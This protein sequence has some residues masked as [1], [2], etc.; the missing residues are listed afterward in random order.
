MPRE[1]VILNLSKEALISSQ[2]LSVLVRPKQKLIFESILPMKVKA[3][4]LMYR[5]IKK[6]LLSA[7][8]FFCFIQIASAASIDVYVHNVNG[9]VVS[10]A[11]VILYPVYQTMYTD[12][13]GYVR[14]YGLDYGNFTYEVYYD[15]T[16][17]EEF[18]GGEE[19]ISLQEPLITRDFTRNWPYKYDDTLPADPYVGETIAITVTV[20]N[21]L[22]FSRNVKVE[23]WVDRS[24]TSGWDYQSLSNAQSISGGGST[25][26]FT[27]NNITPSDSG[28]YYYKA[29]VLSWNDGANNGAGGYIV[30]DTMNWEIAFTA[31]YQTSTVDIYVENVNGSKIE[32]AEV[33]LGGNTVTTDINGRARF[34]SVI[35]D[36]YPYEV[37]YDGTGTREFWGDDSIE[38][39]GPSESE[40]FRRNW[41]YK[42]DGTLPPDPYVGETVTITVTVRNNL[43]IPRNVKV[44]LWVDRNKTTDGEY[45][46]VSNAQSISGGGSTK[47]FT[48]NN[49]TPSDS[50]TYYYKAHVLS[51]NDG[52]NN[53]AGGYI[54]TDT[55]NWD[56]AF[57]VETV[58]SPEQELFDDFSYD[59]PYDTN[60][61][62]A[63]WYIRHGSGGGPGSSDASWSRD[64]VQFVADPSDPNNTLL[65][66]IS[67]THGTS[68]T[69]VQA[70][71]GYNKKIF[72]DGTFAARVNFAQ[73]PILWDDLTVQAFFSINT[74]AP[75]AE[76]DF[77]YLAYDNSQWWGPGLYETSWDNYIDGLP[78]SEQPR[79][80]DYQSNNIEGWH[81]LLF[82][83]L[84]GRIDYYLDDNLIA[85][86]SEAVYPD[87]WMSIVLQHWFG[88]LLGSSPTLREHGMLVDWIY[89]A[90]SIALSSSDVNAIVN[91]FRL[92]QINH[93]DTIQGPINT[94]RIAYHS[95]TEYDDDDG[96]GTYSLD[97]EIHIIDLDRES[98]YFI[99]EYMIWSNVDHAMNPR[100]SYD[101]KRIVF[102]GLPKNNHP[103]DATWFEALDIFMYDFEKDQLTN[104]SQ[105]AGLGSSIDEDPTFSPDGTKVVFKRSRADLWE[106]SVA[107]YSLKKLTNTD[108]IE[109]S[110][111]RYSPDG[112]WILFWVGSGA[113]SYIAKIPSSGGTTQVVVDNSPGIQDYFPSYWGSDR[114][115]YTSW[116]NPQYY[117]DDIKIYNLSNSSDVFAAFNTASD[118]SDPFS[119]ND[120][121][122]GFST[123]HYNPSGKWD[124]WY[125]NPLTGTAQRFEFS[126]IDK[127]DLGGTY[128]PY[129][130]NFICNPPNPPSGLDVNASS[131]TIHL[132][133]SDNSEN[134][135]GFR[136]YRTDVPGSLLAVVPANTTSYLDIS[137]SA[138]TQYCYTV[139][140]F[141]NTCG[142]SAYSNQDCATT[143]GPDITI[144][145]SIAP[146]DDLQMPFGEITAGQSSEAIV[147]ITNDGAGELSIGSIGE[148]N[149]LGA[150]F[151]IENDSCSTGILSSGS[152][153][154]FTVRFETV[155]AGTFSDSFDIPS[156]DTDEYS[157]TID[158]SGSAISAR[159]TN[160]ILSVSSGEYAALPS[161]S[162]DGTQ[163]S[164]GLYSPSEGFDIWVMNSDGSGASQKIVDNAFPED[165][166]NDGFMYLNSSWSPDG[167][168]IAYT[169]GEGDL[170]FGT[171]DI[172]IINSEGT[173]TPFQITTTG[174]ARMPSWSPDGKKIVYIQGGFR[175]DVW[176]IWLINSDGTGSPERITD[177]GFCMWP[178]WSPDGKRIS[179]V[180]K[181]EVSGLNNLWVINSDGSGVPLK[182][183][184]NVANWHNDA[185]VMLTTSWSPDGSKICYIHGENEENLQIWI[186]NSN[187]S[188]TPEQIITDRNFSIWP[189][190]S[191]DGTKL[192][193]SSLSTTGD[194]VDLYASDYLYEDDAFPSVNIVFPILHQQISGIVDI[195]GTVMDNLS[196]DGTTILSS[197]S[198][199][200]LEYGEG[201]EPETWTNIVSSSTPKYNEVLTSW[202][203]SSLASGKYT[204]RLRATDGVNEN[205]QSVA[206][207]LNCS[208]ERATNQILSV[209]LG[210]AA[211]LPFYSPDGIQLSYGMYS[212][213]EGFDIWV[214]NT[215]GGGVPQKIVNDAFPVDWEYANL[216]LLSSS[217]SPD[218]SKIAYTKAE[219]GTSD[220]WT[221]N[222]DGS[223]T[224][225]QITTNGKA[226]MPSWS[227]D[228]KKIASIINGTQIW[229]VNSDGTGIPEQI[230]ESSVLAW[231]SWSP[232]GKQISYM[233]YDQVTHTHDLWV[234]N[235][236]GTGNPL[237]IVS[238][239][240]VWYNDDSN[241][242]LTTSW[243]PDG[244][245]IC[246]IQGDIE[247]NIQIWV[248]N[249]DGSG[250]PAP[251]TTTTGMN[252]HP[253]WPSWAPDG[254]KIVYGSVSLNSPD[255]FYSNLYITD[256][257]YED[258]AYPAVNIVSPILHQ[259][260]SGT[261]E[262][263]GTVTD[264]LS[265][266]GTTILSSLS[267]WTLEYGE[268]E[269]P[270]TWTNIVTSSIPKYNEV[271]ASWD[272]SSLASGR[273]TI[274][275]RATDGVDENFQSVIVNVNNVPVGF[276][277]GDF[278]P[279]GDVDGSDL[280]VFIAA[281]STG[282][283]LADLDS[284]GVLDENDLA[285]FAADFGRTDCHTPYNPDA[286]KVSIVSDNDYFLVWPANENAVGYRVF[287]REE[288]QS[289]DFNFPDW[290]GTETSCTLYGLED[291]KTYYF[292][293]RYYDEYG[294]EYI[295][296]TELFVVQ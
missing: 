142:E 262:I 81:T 216:W 131:D 200:T 164:Y 44:E 2:N 194:Y 69:S 127:H 231:P 166:G 215:D 188:G 76:L 14:F 157:V 237:K 93:K 265:V 173:G 1:K 266:D 106:L 31:N 68:N 136:I 109:E 16:G 251:I 247:E 161:Y 257:L 269:E 250:T 83:V 26:T 252:D 150:P 115:I 96:D 134:E 121:I 103:T 260:M 275:L 192:V 154:T 50:G 280:N 277:E 195:V 39:N 165:W 4:D 286:C 283:F 206:V 287:Y 79:E 244:S 98:P 146:S 168:K 253:F 207:S 51:W 129:I 23:L 204:L 228:G 239:V 226:I 218:R 282:N 29:H 55:M 143:F 232:D 285:I 32:G 288:G 94:G 59:S 72:L 13:N 48:F 46:S 159:T 274:R 139:T 271:L 45:H 238:N 52:A 156:S 181:D 53:G 100:F 74:A 256:Y 202:D 84:G 268:G 37:Y 130:V 133:W 163:I 176:D 224:P 101:G 294:N 201:E 114:I 248:T 119:I 189:T 187:G 177:G 236:D 107:D 222:S 27:F 151:Y 62:E 149:P 225:L 258:D 90:K 209:S 276:C 199:W 5:F 132:S 296:C 291:D 240:A 263:I 140:A 185:I 190:W 220:I 56:V 8:L 162:P 264:N 138:E 92:S 203:T 158:V 35:Y 180:S 125:G 38:V 118:D 7:F 174:N 65:K 75:Y 272:T 259:Q 230:V 211:S 116:D 77:E 279:D 243:S 169:K 141:S 67:S 18:W 152:S 71:I 214:M 135:D 144:S 22:S 278:E 17:E 105:A 88:T 245:K 292:S 104:L 86:H 30:T 128:T 24:K 80:I 270:E 11:K 198:S 95:Y 102:M 42:Y 89:H 20:R 19:D 148:A 182:I 196:V 49:I 34:N 233:S 246:Y 40:T 87:T 170:F 97:G 153:C 289:F 147:T 193:Y 295:L 60:I 58:I 99:G 255:E 178:S 167:T 186:V 117:D 254:T 155:I 212:P 171:S 183:L 175:S 47:T 85:S 293:V 197:L 229:L 223:G 221:I 41:P 172:W 15:G 284:S 54:V 184:S 123:N 108:S 235:S 261:F 124:L 25:K 73:T 112:N 145:D 36:T 12:A 57:N 63:G 160:Q 33:E 3:N 179:Y 64:N 191:P 241:I 70:E 6:L 267:S 43:S 28:T 113:N 213:T 61:T 208:W 227:P 126:N 234:V 242:P 122:I 9:S 120:N 205:V 66:L 21:N 82:Q 273:Y 137:T 110:G 78:M 111:P 281:F 210:E 91:N 249:S 290:E 10:G 217:W 219:S